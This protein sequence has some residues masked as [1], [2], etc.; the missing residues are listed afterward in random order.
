MIRVEDTVASYFV[1]D[2]E[3][4]GD[5]S[6]PSTC[7]IWEMSFMCVDTGETCNCVIDPDPDVQLFPPPPIPELFHLTRPFLN[8]HC[9]VDFKTNWEKVTRWI[10][11]NASRLP[12]VL[13][14]HNNVLADKPVLEHHLKVHNCII[15]NQWYFFDSLLFF[16]DHY[17]TNDY[18]LKGLVR[19]LLNENHVNAHRAKQDT[20]KLY[21]CLHAFGWNLRGYAYGPFVSSMRKM[22]GVGSKVEHAL[23]LSGFCCEEQIMNHIYN[24][25]QHKPFPYGTLFTY[26]K[27]VLGPYSIP[28]T[29]IDFIVSS[30][31]KK[32]M[33]SNGQLYIQ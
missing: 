12:I 23:I 24:L 29:A 9:A 10:W 6:N 30:V 25:L 27:C 17:K 5:V 11:S 3:F 14:S 8:Q 13:I 33:G 22:G 21:Q 28:H 1:Y 20:V 32:C 26:F 7:K 16:R 31:L 18:S 19:R 15:D 4:I 2:L